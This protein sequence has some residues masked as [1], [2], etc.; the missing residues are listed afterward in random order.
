MR[1]LRES[2]ALSKKAAALVA[3]LA[4]GFAPVRAETVGDAFRNSLSV[5]VD[6]IESG[7]VLE[8]FQIP[9]RIS[10]NASVGLVYSELGIDGTGLAFVDADQ[11]VLPYEVDTWDSSGESLL[12]VNLP[13]ATN[14]VTFTMYWNLKDGE[15]APEYR[16]ADVWPNYAGVWHFNEEI[17]GENAAT[18]VS[19]D[20]TGHG[21][22]AVPTTSGNGNLSEMVS[23]T[24]IYGRGRVN[25]ST[26]ASNRYGSNRL[27]VENSDA[28]QFDPEGS[29]TFSGWVKF[30]DYIDEPRIVSKAG[31]NDGFQVTLH[32]APY[33]QRIRVYGNG[34]GQY[35][36]QNPVFST[37]SPKDEDHYTFITVVFNQGNARVYGYSGGIRAFN[38]NLSLNTV[39]NNMYDL[40]FGGS[41]D[42]VQRSMWGSYDEFRIR[43]GVVD[44]RWTDAQYM[45][46]TSPDFLSTS[47]VER[48]GRKVNYWVV[49]P[50]VSP[51]FWDVGAEPGV[52]SQ[53]ELADGGAITN[54]IYEVNAPENV[55]SSIA[56]IPSDRTGLFRVVFRPLDA[57][58]YEGLTREVSFRICTH[59]SY[60]DIG[61]VKGDSGRVL[62]MNRDAN[63]DC[64]IDFQGYSDT[65]AS[66]ATYWEFVND[67]GAPNGSQLPFNLKPGTESILRNS[68]GDELW[69]LKDCRHG[70]TYPKGVTTA[71]EGLEPDQN[72]L[73]W[74]ATSYSFLSRLTPA[75]QNTVGQ[76]VMRN[77]ED[78]AVCSSLLTTGVGAIYFDAVNGW[79][80]GSSETGADYQIV[81]EVSTNAVEYSGSSEPSYEDEAGEWHAVE[82]IPFL[83]DGTEG[84][85]RLAPTNLLALAVKNGGTAGNFYRVVVPF[86]EEINVGFR[87]VPSL[88]FR[89]RRVSSKPLSIWG[90]DEGGMI[91]L[92][93]LIVSYP[94]M[95][96]DLGTAGF[97]DPSDV[98]KRGK[99]LMGYELST[100][101]P[102]PVVGEAVKGRAKAKYTV[103]DGDPSADTSSFVVSAQMYYRWRYLNQ[104]LDGWRYVDLDPSSNLESYQTIELPDMVGDI[105][106]YFV[107]QLN[108]PFYKYVDYSGEGLGVP[109]SEE[110]SEVTNRLG[111]A[112]SLPSGGKDWF[113]RPRRGASEWEGVTVVASGAI[114]KECNMSLISDDMWRAMIMV[115]TNAEGTC[116]ISFKGVNRQT[117]SPWSL[118]VNSTEW[119]ASDAT[120]GAIDLPENGHLVEGG[121]PL[122]FEVDH[123]ANYIEVKVST[124]YFT[125]SIARAEYQNFN[126]WNDAHTSADNP[127]FKASYAETNGVDDVAMTTSAL[128]DEIGSW[129]TFSATNSYWDEVF[130]LANYND[131]S[132]PK[133][134]VYQTH[135]TPVNWDGYN[136]SFE[137]TE[138]VGA[139]E[140]SSRSGMGAKLLGQSKGSLVFTKANCP[141]G[142]DNVSFRARLGQS[143]TFDGISWHPDAIAKKNYVFFTP[144]TMSRQ[145][146]SDSVLGKDM[147]VGASVS[148]VGYYRPS[149]GCYEFRAERIYEGANMRLS[150]YKWSIGATGVMEPTCLC[151]QDFTSTRRMWSNDSSAMLDS[152]LYY[153]MFISLENTDDG[154]TRIIC[155]LSQDAYALSAVNPVSTF[156]GQKWGGLTYEDGSNPFTRGSYGVISKDCASEYMLPVCYNT[157]YGWANITPG[158]DT[159]SV[160]GGKYFNPSANV[161]SFAGTESYTDLRESLREDDWELV[162]GR[163]ECY[164][165]A[166]MTSWVGIWTPKDLEQSVDIY[167]QSKESDTADW[168]KF[169]STNV[170][171]Y[172]FRS[173]EVPLNVAGQW[174]LKLATGAYNVDVVL[175]DIRQYQWQAPD[176]NGRVAGI[177]GETTSEMFAYT[178]GI[179][180]T[181]TTL[182]ANQIVLQPARGVATRPVSV[183]SPTLQ[184]LG[185]LA[186]SYTGV[187]ENAEIWVQV[188]TNKVDNI[189]EYNQSVASVEP[190][191]SE[192][193]GLWLNVAKYTYADLGDAGSKSIYLGWH[194]DGDRDRMGLFRLFVPTGT[195]ASAIAAATNETRNVNYGSITITG[196]TVTDEP[197]LSDRAWR[198]WNLRTIGDSD[199]TERRMYL[200]DS[201][202]LGEDGTGLDCGLNNSLKNVVTPD[203]TMDKV[204]SGYPAVYSPTFKSYGAKCGVGSVMFTA[205]LYATDGHAKTSGGGLVTLYGSTSSISENWEKIESFKIGSSVFADYSWTASNQTYAAI[206]IEVP[207]NDGIYDRVILD[208][209]TVSEKVQPSL[210]FVYAR[211]FR[212]NGANLVSTDPITDILSPNEQPLAGESWG[213]QA[214]LSLKQ[215]ADEID[216]EKGITVTLAYYAEETMGGYPPS[217]WG[218]GNWQ[219]IAK[220]NG[221]IEIPL[222]Q[223]GEPG[224][225]IFRSVGDKPENLVKPSPAPGTVVQYQ[226]TAKYY[227]RE[228]TEYT[229][230]VDN[231]TQPDW[232]YPIDHNKASGATDP[233]DP[234]FSPY[235][236][237]DTVS[238]GRAWIN[239]VNWN[240]GD[241]ANSKNQFIE[242]CVPA[243]VDMTGWFLRLNDGDSRHTPWTMAIFGYGDLAGDEGRFMPTEKGTN[244]YEF[245]VLQSPATSV[246]EGGIRDTFDGDTLD[247]A[248][249]YSDGIAGSAPRGELNYGYP[250]QFELVRPS[251]VIEHQFVMEGTNTWA[252]TDYEAYASGT[253][254]FINMNA[255]DN[256]P[257]RFYAGDERGLRDGGEPYG[258]DNIVLGSSGVT[259]SESD[260]GIT[261]T[262]KGGMMFTP[263]R[264][265]EGQIIPENWFIVPSGENAWV[266]FKV[267]GEHISQRIGGETAR[268]TMIVVPMNVATNVV[269]TADPWYETAYLDVD[270]EMIEQ[271]KGGEWTY[272]Y[273]PTQ[274]TCHVTAYDAP[275]RELVDD[276]GLKPENRYTPA[277]IRWLAEGWPYATADELVLAKY[278]GLKDTDSESNLTL[279]EMYWLDIP[280]VTASGETEWYLRGGIVGSNGKSEPIPT[281]ER[282]IT[283]PSGK[284][285][286]LT[287]RLL[288]AKLY[289]ENTKGNPNRE[290]VGP[291]YAPYRLQGLGNEKS[292]ENASNWT[293]VTFQVEAWLRNGEMLNKGYLPFRQFVFDGGSFRPAGDEHEFESKIEILDPH[294]T[295]SP[296]Y[297]YGWSAASDVEAWWRWIIS[298]TNR[299]PQSVEVLRMEDTYGDLD[300][301]EP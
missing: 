25:G 59:N 24:G 235:T 115:P 44:Y 213:V 168:I 195:V 141:D 198:G 101:T 171:S 88:R 114:E 49:D 295:L 119:G 211:P 276:F 134:I 21:L 181:N 179:V 43:R 18:T 300:E 229:Q 3:L 126:H 267:E 96:A 100:S 17:T 237:L 13:V 226:L 4:L 161:L 9:L 135:S 129:K 209:I 289:I 85:E 33:R 79:T 93:N 138:L 294:S 20:S 156:S 61:G 110:V 210:G 259:G 68:G 182:K 244:G 249:W 256:S 282:T 177:N 186:F 90:P 196:V 199:D 160:A 225:M 292:D 192:P 287:N 120:A 189:N 167:L 250:L 56:E 89:I 263:G 247:A 22:D 28:L 54:W 133:G 258:W 173:F 2:F 299:L 76:I 83:R 233:A 212:M 204:A 232:Y 271:H 257:I 58:A 253:N 41:P 224:D 297:S 66:K 65:S 37:N 216:I 64:P 221:N 183:R 60:G 124:R 207:T 255:A 243:G 220:A 266:Y 116:T 128:A 52:I 296:G 154:K 63:Q 12:W 162:Y 82:M 281:I 208:E 86:S 280:P 123:N 146:Q 231:W 30:D 222:E 262:W 80:D 113:F 270:G 117:G 283:Y 16:P 215:L 125:W 260:P 194:Y 130:S 40:A 172:G 14:G 74:S 227:D 272:T 241:D 144:A 127:F 70:N 203:G 205:R 165:N 26:L 136:L 62:L 50:S 51:S 206:K 190:G 246:S 230:T 27:V 265:N 147:A 73:P 269:Y 105:E 214:Q 163:A 131:P 107:S 72:Y 291:V 57:D 11:N 111:S 99:T 132:F 69:H 87:G 202:L 275:L 184:G 23:T 164:T 8:N 46:A 121:V 273:T 15:T 298:S 174:N 103:N 143:M 169:A 285:L 218:W 67:D 223:V 149:V 122:S 77:V 98:S 242:V 191:E 239:E 238:P 118:D 35:L 153:G 200:E 75:R 234:K 137:S 10:E 197:E 178:Q 159:T 91:L 84:F 254:L 158:G 45:A 53:G 236:I 219:T 185:R 175:D 95:C 36:S 293:S 252:G 81:V 42:G 288:T 170:V 155:G 102:F 152:Q 39:T 157:P 278:K 176:Y 248:V 140:Q 145:T 47:L 38:E 142:I 217:V 31:S 71:G 284:T 261:T 240:D 92:D 29:F 150:L 7:A 301:I 106:Y 251:G 264:L 188:A 1:S 104:R 201:T 5:T 109:Y 279:T 148:V 19:K 108:A 151:A 180:E 286:V 94:A 6:G 187:D 112:A 55:Y 34:N 290:D 277:V 97:Y 32:E 193:I 48:D 139:S 268:S 166:T 245:V 228:G 274:Q 78:A